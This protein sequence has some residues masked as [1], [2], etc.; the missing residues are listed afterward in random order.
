MNR[1]SESSF[2]SAMDSALDSDDVS[3]LEP[4]GLA[5]FPRSNERT[6]ERT[7]QTI[8]QSIKS[9]VPDVLATI[10]AFLGVETGRRLR[11]AREAGLVASCYERMVAG[12]LQEVDDREDKRRRLAA[13]LFGRSNGDRCPSAPGG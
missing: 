10:V 7:N 3:S 9:A 1:C 13:K 5:H 11:N 2:D 6:N 12:K 4:L 8:K